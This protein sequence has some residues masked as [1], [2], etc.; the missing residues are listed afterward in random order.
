MSNS[1]QKVSFSEKLKKG[2]LVK[3][4][5]FGKI[6]PPTTR[7]RNKLSNEGLQVKID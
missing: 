4:N 5:F 3:S 7:E 2:G 1:S 6:L